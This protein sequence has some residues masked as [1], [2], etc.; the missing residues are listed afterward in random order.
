MFL[1]DN[2]GEMILV[3]Y[4]KGIFPKHGSTVFSES[5]QL[6]SALLLRKQLTSLLPPQLGGKKSWKK[7]QQIG[8]PSIRPWSCPPA[9][10]GAAAAWVVNDLEP[11]TLTVFPHVSPVLSYPYPGSP[12][13]DLPKMST[14]PTTYAFWRLPLYILPHYALL[15]PSFSSAPPGPGLRFAGPVGLLSGSAFPPLNRFL[16]LYWGGR[17]LVCRILV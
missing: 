10:W 12:R 9:P 6:T 1:H 14:L 17:R 3:D 4:Y 16:S 13:G 8:P 7:C 15:A 2:F 5:E 11:P